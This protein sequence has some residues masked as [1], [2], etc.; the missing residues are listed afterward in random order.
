MRQLLVGI[1]VAIRGEK[2]YRREQS[3][4]EKEIG[5]NLQ[6]AAGITAT[7]ITSLAEREESRRKSL[8]EKARS[9]LTVVAVCSALVFT[10]LTFLMGQGIVTGSYA[11]PILLISFFLS[12]LYFVGGAVFALRALQIDR[13]WA[14]NLDDERQSSGFVDLQVLYLG[15]N[16]LQTNIKAN[17]IS[18]SFSCLRN[19]VV[20][21]LVFAAVVVLLIVHPA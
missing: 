1:P 4:I 18:V 8:E 5:K 20:S 10:G 9:N 3:D 11:K 6:G 15:L 19:A 13:T 17:W 16:T 12:V 14:L 2:N 7:A 21:I